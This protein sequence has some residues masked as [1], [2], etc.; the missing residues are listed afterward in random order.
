MRF[1]KSIFEKVLL[2]FSKV[3][4]I[5]KFTL[6]IFNWSQQLGYCKCCFVYFSE[7]SW[8]YNW[9]DS[10][11]VLK[12]WYLMFE[13]GCFLTY[14]NNLNYSNS[15]C[16]Y[17]C[18]FLSNLGYF[19]YN[20]KHMWEFLCNLGHWKISLEALLWGFTFKIILWK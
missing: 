9:N 4:L 10:F 20:C 12:T 3:K 1:S 11:N 14:H 17:A 19:K 18:V 2:K 15:N 13:I 16:N 8:E 7:V 6:S 5:F